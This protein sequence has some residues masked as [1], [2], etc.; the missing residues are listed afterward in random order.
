MAKKLQSSHLYF[1]LF[2][3]LSWTSLSA[4]A[5]WSYPKD[6]S[7]IESS[8]F[9]SAVQINDHGKGIA[10][11][12]EIAG[13]NTVARASIFEEGLWSD[14]ITLNPT[15]SVSEIVTARDVHVA[16]NNKGAAVAVWEEGPSPGPTTIKS[17]KLIKNVWTKPVVIAFLPDTPVAF[18]EV[19]IDKA[20]NAMAIWTAFTPSA[21]GV[22]VA[23]LP[24]HKKSWSTP[25]TISGSDTALFQAQIANGG[26]GNFIAVWLGDTILKAR[27]LPFKAVLKNQLLSPTVD[28]TT[29]QVFANGPAISA[30]SQGKAAVIWS[31]SL[32]TPV[33]IELAIINSSIKAQMFHFRHG[34]IS[35][36]KPAV[37]LAD[38]ST[39]NLQ[40]KIQIN[41]RGQAVAAWLQTTN[42]SAYT[43]FASVFN[44]RRWNAS[45]AI[46]NPSFPFAVSSQVGI[47]GKGNAIAVWIGNDNAAPSA[48]SGVQSSIFHKGHWSTPLQLSAPGDNALVTEVATNNQGKTIALWKRNFSHTGGTVVQAS[49]TN[50][51]H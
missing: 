47:D 13:P 26:K 20:G 30:N 5:V 17:A 9:S 38:N 22:Q 8:T 16:I 3:F 32:V 18:S 50:I 31:E 42:E 29:D 6:L 43:V 33:G 11:W 10:V 41:H 15:T 4:H 51:K 37:T 44:G 19:A 46:S 35:H 12:L 1:I 2:L 34:I 45:T 48:F 14:P 21:S 24:H 28:L 7:T 23:G 25:V 40:P 36:L 39:D 49:D 27:P